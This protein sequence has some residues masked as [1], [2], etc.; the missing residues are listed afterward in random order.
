MSAKYRMQANYA[1]KYYN[2]KEYT[3]VHIHTCS[4]YNIEAIQVDWGIKCLQLW[5][6]NA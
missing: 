2:K 5:C 6:L 1:I 3:L 4:T